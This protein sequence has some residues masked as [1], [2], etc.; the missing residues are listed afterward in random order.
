MAEP[1]SFHGIVAKGRAVLIQTVTHYY[2][3]TIVDPDER[4]IL[5]DPV[6]WCADTGRL[7]AALVT[8]DLAEYEEIPGGA[9]IMVPAICAILPW[10]HPMP[11]GVK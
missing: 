9:I 2:I 5:L 8:G 1:T 7:N 3:G 11:R 10:S 4:W 6:V